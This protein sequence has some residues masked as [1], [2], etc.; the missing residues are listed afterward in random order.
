MNSR[1][2]TQSPIVTGTSVIALKYKG[3]VMMAADTLGSYGSLARFTDQR[4]LTAVHNATLVGAGGDFSD[5]QFIKDKLDELEV[6]DFNKDDGCGTTAPEIYHYLQRL[7]YHRRNKFDP[8]WNTIVVGGLNQ[9]TNEPFLGQV[10]MIGLAFEG[11]YIATGFGHHLGM[12]LLRKQW[13]PDMEETDARKLL[14]DC[15]RVCFY[16]DCRT[17]NRVQ[18]AKVTAEGVTIPEPVKMDTKWDYAQFVQTK[19]EVGSS[20]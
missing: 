2:R 12:P 20:W 6:Y 15:M 5:F 4:R 18:F 17:I 1:Q 16:R 7:F 14:E 10:T 8:L 9:E 3:G 19:S 11:D 13:Q